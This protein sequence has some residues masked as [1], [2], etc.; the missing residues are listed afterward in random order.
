MDQQPNS[1]DLL[2]GL[3]PSDSSTLPD[4]IGE[5]AI[6]VFEDG[7]NLVIKAPMAGVKANNLELTLTD[8]I[9]SI[10]GERRAEHQEKGAHHYVEE[11]YWGSFERTYTLPLAVESEKAKATLKDG[12]LTIVILKKA[13][14]NKTQLIEVKTE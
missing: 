8:D 13:P 5:L 3:P 6:D 2:D 10:K 4:E 1:Q 11:C 7:D 12:L 14:K 9:I